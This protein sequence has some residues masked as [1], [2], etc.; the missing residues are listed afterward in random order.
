MLPKKRRNHT[1]TPAMNSNCW[2][3]RCAQGTEENHILYAS[4]GG[5]SNGDK[6]NEHRFSGNLFDQHTCALC[7]ES[8]SCVLMHVC[9]ELRPDPSCDRLCGNCIVRGLLTT[10]EHLTAFCPQRHVTPVVTGLFG[11]TLL[12]EIQNI[13]CTIDADCLLAGKWTWSFEFEKR[14]DF[15]VARSAPKKGTGVTKGANDG[16]DN[17][18]YN[19]DGRDS[20]RISTTGAF[21]LG[22]RRI[23]PRRAAKDA[24]AMRKLAADKRLLPI[25]KEQIAKTQ[26]TPPKKPRAPPK[27]A[28][29]AKKIP[30]APAKK[31]PTALATDPVPAPGTDPLPA[32][33]PA[34]VPDA[35]PVPRRKVAKNP[36]PPKVGINRAKLSQ[37]PQ[38]RTARMRFHHL[39]LLVK[40]KRDNACFFYV[41]GEKLRHFARFLPPVPHTLRSTKIHPVTNVTTHV[42]TSVAHECSRK[43]NVTGGFFEGADQETVDVPL[44]Q[45]QSASGKP[46]RRT[47]CI[48]DAQCERVWRRRR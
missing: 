4:C 11:M 33:V 47:S 28:G 30:T 44:L 38:K 34:P 20:S 43:R 5:Q 19:D 41:I 1:H 3:T 42:L 29:P 22:E 26:R 24:T 32:P 9:E 2:H 23:Q 36:P 25:R 31:I 35:V 7:R 48:S 16:D 6:N 40:V 45:R 27:K 8:K 46:G 15:G 12:Q 10:P 14:I 13:V 39:D 18:G 37:K 17:D 21:S